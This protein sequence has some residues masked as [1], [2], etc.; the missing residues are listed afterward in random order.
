LF[1]RQTEMP[2]ASRILGMLDCRKLHMGRYQ[3][4]PV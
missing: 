3:L 1:A 4:A 2:H